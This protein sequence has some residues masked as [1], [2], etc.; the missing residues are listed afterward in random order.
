M[1]NIELLR[2]AVKWAE[3]EHQLGEASSWNQNMYVARGADV[4]RTC[5]TAYCI[6][7]YVYRETTGDPSKVEDIELIPYTAQEELGIT[8]DEAWN[9][10]Q[11][12]GLFVMDRSIT[13]IREIAEKIAA[14]HGE[15]L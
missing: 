8:R 1:F 13:M 4:G 15:V 14:N 10:S 2:Q 11:G 6:A 9:S 7:G 3:F 12:L 5:G